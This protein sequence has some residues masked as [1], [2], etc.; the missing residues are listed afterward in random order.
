MKQLNKDLHLQDILSINQSLKHGDLNFLDIISSCYNRIKK[1]ETKINA[2]QEIIPIDKQI[3]ANDKG[4]L[5]GLCLGVKDIFATNDLATS[6]GTNRS[7][8]SGTKGGFDSR[9]ISK[10]RA[11]GASI[12]GTNKTSEFAVHK[13]TNTLNPRN[14]KLIPGT[15]SSGSAAAVA[16]DHI[17]ISIASQTAGSIAR[18][19]SYCGVIGF[20]PSFGE[21]PR[22]GVLKT[23]E[24][25][26]TIGIIGNSVSNIANVFNV[27]RVQGLNHPLHLNR[28]KFSVDENKFFYAIGPNFDS[29]SNSLR[30]N[31]INYI[32]Q[33]IDPFKISDFKDF[34]KIDF[35]K[36]R[37]IHNDIYAKELSYFLKNELLSP[38]ISKELKDFGDYGKTISHSV[39]KKNLVCLKSQRQQ[40]E[41]DTKNAIIFAL[42]ASNEAPHVGSEEKL[43]ANLFWTALGLPQISLP[44]LT[45]EFGNPIGL[46]IIGYRGS[47]SS[48]LHFAQTVFSKTT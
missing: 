9:V 43:D 41:L 34:S 42:S 29:A 26:D 3:S 28:S 33:L 44:L 25:F 38:D 48:L 6:M 40:S 24:S 14:V 22:T 16:A 18:P 45:S 46:S 36:L 12:I 27:I 35:P 31:A 13:P 19:A 37:V 23:T 47:D 20:K 32:N 15:S 17:S 2:W 39:Y 1:D 4:A 5:F 21:I 8:W 11:A 30:I 7:T 10:I